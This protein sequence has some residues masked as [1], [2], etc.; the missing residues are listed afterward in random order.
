MESRGACQDKL[1]SAG[2]VNHSTNSSAHY[3]KK[4][5]CKLTQGRAVGMWGKGEEGTWLTSLALTFRLWKRLSGRAELGHNIMQ[6]EESIDAVARVACVNKRRK[7]ETWGTCWDHSRYGVSLKVWSPHLIK[8]GNELMRGG[9]LAKLKSSWNSRATCHQ[10][11]TH[12]SSCGSGTFRGSTSD[13]AICCQHPSCFS[14]L[15]QP[16]SATNPG[17]LS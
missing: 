7:R 11:Q 15:F 9:T 5:L 1:V 2:S 10:C 16:I 12:M 14:R 3:L 4:A 8:W 13:I 17:I 6:Q